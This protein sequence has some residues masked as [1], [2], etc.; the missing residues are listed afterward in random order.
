MK[1]RRSE[2][3]NLTMDLRKLSL[4]IIPGRMA[5]CRFEPTAPLPDSI[6]KADF[7]SLTRTAAELTLVCPEDDLAPGTT[8]EA[9]GRCFKVQGLLDFSEIGIIFSLTRPLAKNG[10][11]VF[12]ISTFETDYFMVKEKDL[13]KAIDA[14]SAEGHQ[15]DSED[16]GQ[17]TDDR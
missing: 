2:Q 7:Y 16:R 1:G 4:K 12:V 6:A 9:G 15:V 17:R 10:V 13:A 8:S 11:S 3:Q 14:L 5:V